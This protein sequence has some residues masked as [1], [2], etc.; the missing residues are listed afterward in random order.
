M[1]KGMLIWNL[2]LTGLTGFL[3]FIHFT[4][5]QK[6]GKT[7]AGGQSAAKSGDTRQFRIAYFEMDSLATKLEL[8][9]NVKSEL[10]KR[11]EAMTSELDRLG[12]N[13]QD[14][15]NYYLSQGQAGTLSQTQS[16]AASQ[17]LKKLDDDMKLRK[18][19]LEQ[20]YSDY[21]VRRQNEI[22]SKIEAFLREYNKGKDYSYIISYEQGLFYFKDTAYNITADVISGMNAMYPPEKK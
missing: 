2:V 4:G 15:Y 13:F 11:E 22:K 17:E 12:R 9:K 20:D 6:S 8:V 10:S 16:E 3:L 14:K 1:K 19:Q 21:M 18:Q 7:A 5:G